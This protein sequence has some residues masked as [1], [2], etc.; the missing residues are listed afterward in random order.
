MTHHELD[1]RRN[2]CSPGTLPRSK[3][4]FTSDNVP[5]STLSSE[6]NIPESLRV[7][8]EATRFLRKSS[9]GGPEAHALVS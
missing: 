2:P 4:A 8:L 3:T 6:K 9:E 7:H 1:V 5:T